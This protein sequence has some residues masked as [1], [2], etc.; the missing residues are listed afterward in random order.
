MPAEITEF[1]GKVGDPETFVDLAAFSLC[2][3]QTV[4]QKLLETL[5]IGARFSLF[6]RHL[7]NE[8]EGIKLHRK[9]QAG[10]PDSRISDN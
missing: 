3:S 6:N 1:L 5:N 10:L 9:L 2:D 8:I 7:R 4:K